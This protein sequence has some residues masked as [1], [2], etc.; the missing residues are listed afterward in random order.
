MGFIT[1]TYGLLRTGGVGSFAVYILSKLG[2]NVI[3]QVFKCHDFNV[4][5]SRE[6]L[7]IIGIKKDNQRSKKKFF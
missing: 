4:P 5:Q 2:Y 3:Y 6:R 1:I 7:I